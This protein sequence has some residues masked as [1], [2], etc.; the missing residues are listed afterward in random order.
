MDMNQPIGTTPLDRE[1]GLV[2]RPIDRI[3]GRL[4]VTGRAPYAYE[5]RDLKNPAYG[6]VVEATIAKGSI[7]R[8]DIDAARRAPGVLLVLTHDNVPEQGEKKEQVF[9]QLQGTD[10]RF[11]GQPSPSWWPRPSSRPAQRPPW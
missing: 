7:R 4:K 5:V 1:G 3:D 11:H 10:I 2:G 8:L 6:F 9:P